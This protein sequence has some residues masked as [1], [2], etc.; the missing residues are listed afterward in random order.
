VVTSLLEKAIFA[1]QHREP[2]MRHGIVRDKHVTVILS[3]S[4]ELRP[5]CGIYFNLHSPYNKNAL[6]KT[7]KVIG[8]KSAE[9][10][11]KD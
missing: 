11:T 4:D 8:E 3:Q 2:N 5:L 9:A 1:Y 7:V 6:P 10:G